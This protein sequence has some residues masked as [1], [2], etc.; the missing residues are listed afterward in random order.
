L[1]SAGKKFGEARDGAGFFGDIDRFRATETAFS[2]VS[3]GK[4]RKVKVYSGDARKPG[5][6][7]TAW[8]RPQSPGGGLGIARHDNREFFAFS[9]EK[10]AAG[11]T[12]AADASKFTHGVSG[13]EP[14]LSGFLLL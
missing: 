8:W 14:R 12:P 11:E 1:Y 9:G 10:Q 3:A 2:R 5:S 6:R 13:L 7:R 4:P